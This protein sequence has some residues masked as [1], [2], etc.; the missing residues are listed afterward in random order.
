MSIPTLR[1]LLQTQNVTTHFLYLHDE[2]VVVTADKA[3]NNIVFVC[4]NHVINC[5]IAELG[6][7]DSA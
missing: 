6:I 3:L 2:H 5:F 1:Q 7:A 4:N